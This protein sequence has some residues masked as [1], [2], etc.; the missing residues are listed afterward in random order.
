MNRAY[1]LNLLAAAIVSI[2]ALVAVPWFL[3]SSRAPDNSL[4]VGVVFGVIAVFGVLNL[5]LKLI[6]VEGLTL[7]T[8]ERTY[9]VAGVGTLL[10]F[11]LWL[12]FGIVRY[13]NAPIKRVGEG[14][15]DKRGRVRSESEY[16]AFRKWEGSY[17][18]VAVPVALIGLISLPVRR[19]DGKLRVSREAA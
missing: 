1:R 17:A 10:L 16:R 4:V 9:K 7:P 3:L 11:T 8:S 15:Q 19:R 2:A 13:P 12:A 14:F 18:I 5:G 6:A